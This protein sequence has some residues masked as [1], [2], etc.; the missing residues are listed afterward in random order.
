MLAVGLTHCP[1]ASTASVES[2]GVSARLQ[3]PSL[4][5]MGLSGDLMSHKQG[6][7]CPLERWQGLVQA[8]ASVA[9]ALS[10]SSG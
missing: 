3:N 7:V 1:E 9:G 6:R 4:L 8:Q 10:P 5:D 2:A